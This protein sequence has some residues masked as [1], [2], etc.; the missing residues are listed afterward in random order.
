MSLVDALFRLRACSS[1][2]I[3]EATNSLI[4]LL[5]EASLNPIILLS[6]LRRGLT[7]YLSAHSSDYTSSSQSSDVRGDQKGRVLENEEARS[8]GRLFGLNGMGMC[9]L[10]L[11][12]EVVVAESKLMEPLI[13]EV[14]LALFHATSIDFARLLHKVTT[15]TLDKLLTPFSWPSKQS[16]MTLERLSPCF[17]AFP[18]PRRI[19]PH[20]SLRRMG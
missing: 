17:P 12:E 1:R 16:S 15:S 14:C 9:V 5:T 7:T 20:I 2:E 19:L 3:L 6:L 13:M 10:R 18:P 8:S 11:P 4:S